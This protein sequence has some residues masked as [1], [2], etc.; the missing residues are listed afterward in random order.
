MYNF[1]FDVTVSTILMLYG[2]NVSWDQFAVHLQSLAKKKD[3]VLY[4][5]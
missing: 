1:D 5:R 4:V 2:T 3:Q